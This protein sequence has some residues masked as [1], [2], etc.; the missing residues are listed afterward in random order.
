MHIEYLFISAVG[1]FKDF[2]DIHW[3]ISRFLCG[4]LGNES[5]QEDASGRE[6]AVNFQCG[7]RVW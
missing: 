1:F 4:N 6:K 3:G 5:W 2:S 7:T